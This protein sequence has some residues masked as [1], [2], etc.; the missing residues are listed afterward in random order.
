M[1]LAKPDLIQKKGEGDEPRARPRTL[2]EALAR[3]PDKRLPGQKVKQEG[4]VRRHLEIASLDAKATLVGAYDAALVEAV[5]NC[6][7][8]LLDAQEYASDYRG[9]VVLQFQLHSDGRITDVNVSENTAGSIPELLCETAVDK[10]NPF[11]P[12]PGD[13]RRIVGEIRNITFTFYYQ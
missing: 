13:M 7:Y 6:W 10:P 2:Q 11:S 4:G 12:F 1:T 5:A 8:G 3:Q 9:K